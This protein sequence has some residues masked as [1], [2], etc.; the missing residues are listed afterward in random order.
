L[1][2][3]TTIKRRENLTKLS[4]T[5]TPDD[6][7]ESSFEMS[8]KS[9]SNNP[10]PSTL[11]R[12][13]Q[14]LQIFEMGWKKKKKRE[15]EREIKGRERKREEEREIDTTSELSWIEFF[16]GGLFGECKA[17]FTHLLLQ[18]VC[19]CECECV[20][21]LFGFKAK[22]LWSSAFSLAPPWCALCVWTNE[23][24]DRQRD[25][26]WLI[27]TTVSKLTKFRPNTY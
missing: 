19:V 12:N 1:L 22:E 7:Q 25:G 14:K 21:I 27:E 3:H 13:F 2:R 18:L 11:V 8:K 6:C 20:C 5:S 26:K 15:R 16:E 9:K 4:F 23:Q 10:L 17:S 24:T